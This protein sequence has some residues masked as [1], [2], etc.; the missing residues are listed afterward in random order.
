MIEGMRLFIYDTLWRGFLLLLLYVSIQN[1]VFNFASLDSLTIT[2]GCFLLAERIYFYT[3]YWQ[4]ITMPYALKLIS[5]STNDARN[6]KVFLDQFVKFD[7][8]TKTAYFYNR[9]A[10][11]CEEYQI[12]RLNEIVH[13]LGI[14]DKPVEVDIKP[15]KHKYVV[16]KFYTLHKNIETES[17]LFHLKKEHIFYGFFKDGKYYLPIQAQT[18]MITVGESGSGKSNFMNLLIFSLLYNEKLLDFIIMI[19]LKAPELSRY[20]GLSYIKFID[21]VEEVDTIFHELKELMNNRFQHM[22]QKNLLVYDGKPIFV[23]IDEV[24]T[25]GTYHDKK[26]KDSIFANMIDIFQKGRAAK[27]ILLLFAQKIDSTNIPTNVLTNIQSKVL[28]KTDSDFNMNNTIGT[29]EDIQLITKTK[30]A[31]FNKGRAILKD[32]LTSDKNLI[33]VPYIRESVQNMMIEF[34]KLSESK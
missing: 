2:I 29:Q 31:D 5:R 8:K 1:S 10:I 11:N 13:Y 12:N 19:D 18:H 7:K 17:P 4:F 3:K 6:N 9:S 21:N 15:Y 26:I 28:M 34:F 22:K 25:I 23:I 30:V 24:G 27:I 32:G 14:H 33:Q 20:N 16:L